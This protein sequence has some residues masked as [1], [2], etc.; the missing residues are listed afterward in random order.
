MT[1]LPDLTG[2]SLDE[3]NELV[4][5]ANKRIGELRQAKIDELKAQRAALDAELSKLTGATISK[6]R[7]PAGLSEGKKRASPK[8]AFRGPNGEEYSGRGA[9]PRWA[10]DLGIADK[11]GLEKYRV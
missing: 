7:M 8:V 5:A 1:K 11:A 4:D 3:L 10:K 2:Y 9:L 6:P